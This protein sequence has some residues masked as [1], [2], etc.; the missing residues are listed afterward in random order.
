MNKLAA[1]ALKHKALKYGI[2]PNQGWITRQQAARQL[3]QPERN[4]HDLLRDAIEARDIE[5]KKFSDWDAATMRPV[6]VT[7]YRIIEPGTPKPAKSSP[8][9]AETIPGIPDDLLPKVREKILAHPHKTASA[10]K[11]LFSTNNRTRLSV[12]AIRGLLDKH[13]QNRR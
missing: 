13:P 6:Q 9:S 1:I 4:V 8:A 2:P 11:D 10:I 12:K 5:T 3:G 7:C